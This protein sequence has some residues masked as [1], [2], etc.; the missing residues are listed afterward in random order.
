MTVTIAQ[1]PLPALRALA[2]GDADGPLG[3]PPSRSRRG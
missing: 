1:L 3:S 2:A